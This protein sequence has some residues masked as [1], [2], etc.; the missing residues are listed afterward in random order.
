MGKIGPLTPEQAK[1]TLANKLGPLADR[2][3]QKNTKFGIRPHRVFL[4][5]T[6]FGGDERGE[7]HEKL[8][9]RLELLP[10]PRVDSLDSVTFSFFHAGTLP[11]GSIRVS[12]ISVAAYTEDTLRGL[13]VPSGAYLDPAM[14]QIPEPYDFFYEVVEDGRGDDEPARER[15]RLLNR[16]FRRAGKVDWT[17]MLERTSPDRT[18]GDE[19]E[20]GA[21]GDR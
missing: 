5:W 13:K 17:L 18:R 2:L 10:T 19:S 12:E 7:G 20:F 6:K 16:P 15:Y 1:K 3:R 8:L 4:T 11:V 21:G 9:A 14:T